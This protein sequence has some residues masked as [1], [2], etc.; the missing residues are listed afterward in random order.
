MRPF[1]KDEQYNL[2]TQSKV[3]AQ[4]SLKIEAQRNRLIVY[5]KVAGLQ[6]VEGKQLI[7]DKV[8]DESAN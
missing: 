4:G 1:L 5:P 2:Q 6:Q 8:F 7:F 3:Q